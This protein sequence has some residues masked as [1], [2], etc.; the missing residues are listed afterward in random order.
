MR[1]QGR[2][3]CASMISGEMMQC[4]CFTLQGD[5]CRYKKLQKDLRESLKAI[6]MNVII[7]SSDGNDA[8]G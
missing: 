4:G 8:I 5:S 1:L 7:F 3:Q 6:A 2:L